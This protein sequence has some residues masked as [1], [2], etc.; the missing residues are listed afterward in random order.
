[1]GAGLGAL[2]DLVWPSVGAGLGA[3]EDLVYYISGS[4]ARSTRGSSVSHQGEQG[5]EH[6]R[7]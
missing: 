7:I 3:L 6:S 4:R 1:M 5:E 2:E